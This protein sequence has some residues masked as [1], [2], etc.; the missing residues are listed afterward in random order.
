GRAVMIGNPNRF[1]MTAK[2]EIRYRQ[3]VPTETELTLYGSLTKD[4]RR[5][6]QAHA[7]IHLPDGEIAAEADLTLVEI[8]EDY[9]SDSDYETLGWRVYTDEEYKAYTRDK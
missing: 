9:V 5:V 3:P 7:E 1:F 8:P 2:M 4:R 6:V